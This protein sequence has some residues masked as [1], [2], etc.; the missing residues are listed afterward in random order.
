M[1]TVRSDISSA[2]D[3]A[4]S[5]H[6]LVPVPPE[7]R[8]WSMF[9]YLALW[10]GMCVCI[11][12]YM[13]ASSLINGGM[14]AMQAL[15]T[16]F[17]GNII[18]LVPMILNGHVG[19]SYGIPFPIYSRISFGVKGAN[20]PAIL[21]AVVACGWFGIQTW[22]GGTTLYTMLQI[23]WPGAAQFPTV[24][25]GFMGVGLI[26]FLCFLAFWGIN[27]LLI[28]KGIESIKV[29]EAYCAP[30]LILSGL[31]LLFWAFNAAHGF[32]ALMDAP[33]KFQTTK[34]FMAFFIPS[35]TG[36]VGFWATL[37]LNIPDFTRYAKDQKAQIYGQALGLPTTMTLIAFI[38][39]A[40]T[41][42]SVVIYGESIWDPIVLIGKFQNPLVVFISMS[43]I[44]LA[45]LAMNVAANVV[46]PA[47]DLANL[48]PSKIDFKKGGL[49]TALIGMVIM[50]WKLIAD[51]TG[52]IFTWLVGYSALLGPVAGILLAD[53]F[54]LRKCRVEVDDLYKLEGKYTYKNG[55]NP[56]AIIALV[57]GVLPNVPGFLLQIKAVP[58]ETFP[59]FFTGIYD[60]AWFIGLAIAGVCYL[61]LMKT[62]QGSVK[63]V[64]HVSDRPAA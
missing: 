45:T 29:L 5:N 7:G 32:G 22:L 27:V 62:Q 23:V 4:L 9:N 55:Y 50:P 26:P 41:S 30:F 21:R 10:V 34:E 19:V 58:S 40:V 39:I 42:A 8:T 24:L 64:I 13:I 20:I 25:P 17:L 59:A 43:A 2:Y 3:A 61:L 15:M 1:E 33:S 18:V 44:A 46:A 11:P 57:V 60:F 36:M 12:S 54:L 31:A 14:N 28:F 53:Y 51:P 49:I 35:L 38:G 47:N 16:V 52:Y 48:A 37:S 63:E 56:A 6:D